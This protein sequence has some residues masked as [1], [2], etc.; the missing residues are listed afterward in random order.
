MA[1]FRTRIILGLECSPDINDGRSAQLLGARS[2]LCAPLDAE[3]AGTGSVSR[4]SEPGHG[5]PPSV[6]LWYTRC[7]REPEVRGLASRLG[8]GE[9]GRDPPTG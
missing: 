4:I 9:E 5:G 3:P 7:A 6:W 2:S 8:M 1:R